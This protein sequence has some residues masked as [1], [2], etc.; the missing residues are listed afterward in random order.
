MAAALL[1][2]LLLGCGDDGDGAGDGVDR[3][4]GAAADA[5]GAPAGEDA[6]AGDEMAVPAGE[7]DLSELLELGIEEYL[8][9]AE[10]IGSEMI[11]GGGGV[12][13]GSIVYDFDPADGP[14]CLRGDPFH[15]SVLDQGSENLVIFLQG[16]GACL[17]FLCA[18]S[19]TAEPR[20]VPQ[21]GVL[22]TGD[23]RNP[24]RD[25]NF[26][27]VPYCDGS[28]FGGDNR[29]EDEDEP[30]IHH[31]QRNFSAALD[32]ALEHFPDAKRVMLAGSSAG[33]WGTIFH[34]A[35]VRSQYPDAELTVMND[36]GVGLAVNRSFIVSEWGSDRYVPP[37]CEEC[38]SSFHLT[39]LQR[40]LLEHDPEARVGVFS[41]WED[42]TIRSFTFSSS[43]ETFRTLLRD[44]TDIPAMAF[45]ERYKR[46]FIDG[47]QHTALQSAFHTTQIDGV[48]LSEWLGLM[49]ERDEAWVELME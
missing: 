3:D 37:S 6:G 9:A 8:G 27:Y 10:P 15:M 2:A 28:V 17:S 41:S 44:Q 46:F 43:G 12:A 31:G 22:D 11:S 39:P 32:R 40:Y 36:A 35:L 23:E 21:L 29:I 18:A 24:V 20:G 7:L 25:W 45:P 48:P 14:V 34:H 49:I 4:G 1:A 38:D 26:V 47:A 33:G 5:G 19:T 42:S 13:D 30:R 16:G